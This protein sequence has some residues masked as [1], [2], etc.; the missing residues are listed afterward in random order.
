MTRADRRGFALPVTVFLVTLLTLMLATG[1]VRVR[2]DNQMGQ[3]SEY[4][5]EALAVAQSGLQ[6]YLATQTTRPPDGDSTRIN[7]PGGYAWVAPRL[8]QRSADTVQ[9]ALYIVRSTGYVIEPA[10]SGTPR[11][12]RTVARFAFFQ[13]GWTDP[14]AALTARNGI[15]RVSTGGPGQASTT[16][17]LSGVDACGQLPA[18]RSVWASQFVTPVNPPYPPIT[19]EPGAPDISPPS[20]L[21]D[22]TRA[23]GPGIIPD[24][25]SIQVGSEA[26]SIQRIAG[27]AVLTDGTGTGLLIVT[28]SLTFS[29]GWAGWQGVI[30]VGEELRLEATQN[31]IQGQV[32]TGLNGVS[33]NTLFGGPG[34]R[35]VIRYNSCS[36]LRA[37]QSLTGFS[38]VSRAW[39]DNWATY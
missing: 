39:I 5:T 37:L 10:V 32:I 31:R 21:I 2:A 7:V 28:G 16:D 9:P 19:Y 36:V 4:T 1:F 29:G 24:Y 27:N 12:M 6:V 35:T 33:A 26:W 8:V 14:L 17:T 15:R 25:N 11:A 13:V 30:L 18:T 3:S 22:W 38:E 23:V 20:V 34:R